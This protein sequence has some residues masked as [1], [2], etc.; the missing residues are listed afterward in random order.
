MRS[1]EVPGHGVERVR[2][3]V[4]D[5]A[6][7]LPR[8]HV[9]GLQLAVVRAGETL[10]AGGVGARGVEDPSPVTSATLF[11]HGSCAKAYT[12]LLAVDLAASGLVDLDAPVRRYLP[13]LELPDPVVATQVTLRDL[14]SHR[15]GLGR[16]DLAWICNPAWSREELVR[17]LRHLPLAQDLR[18]G[19]HYSNLGYVLAGLAIGQVTG[20]S[21]EEQL[22]RRILEPMEMR[23]TWTSLA[24]MYVDGDHAQAHVLR[25][26]RA[27][28]TDYRA[29]DGAGPAGQLVTCAAD[30]ARWL[31]LQL[32]N[33]DKQAL[34][35]DLVA[36][37][38]QLQVTMPVDASSLPEMRVLGYALGWVVGTYRGRRVVWHTGGIDGFLTQIA[39]LPDEQIGVAASANLHSSDLPLATVLNVTDR[40]MDETSESS[41]YDRLHDDQEGEPLASPPEH[42]SRRNAGPRDR[43]APPSQG[44]NAFSAMYRNPGYG[45]LAVTSAGEHLQVRLGAADLQTRHRHFDTWDLHY[46]PLDEDFP[47]TFVTDADGVVAEA[48]SPLDSDSDPVRFRR[49]PAAGAP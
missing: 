35:P 44:L 16:H 5:L 37:T 6:K 28:R 45:D 23:R 41:W 3:L 12:S 21:W 20:S 49:V 26:G 4:D 10:F 30:T 48:V 14:L 18:V 15:S 2:A 40:L 25:E 33:D 46:A 42:A 9:P 8:W 38:H 31:L 43:P 47:L 13:E 17:R 7:E 24:P 32:G 39:L 11:H 29:L 1:S 27:S 22:Q 36:T 19:M 34:S